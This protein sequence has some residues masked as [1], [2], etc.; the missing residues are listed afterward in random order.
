MTS[1][2]EEV[3]DTEETISLALTWIRQ[4]KE[5]VEIA[6]KEILQSDK[7][8]TQRLRALRG[9]CRVC[10]ENPAEELYDGIC[11]SCFD[12]ELC[13]SFGIRRD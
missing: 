11:T 9:A 7:E 2:L 3:R 13:E 6:K 5:Y 12:K 8:A 10:G 4:L 1:H